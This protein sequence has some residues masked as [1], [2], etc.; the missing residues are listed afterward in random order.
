MSCR[1]AANWMR[2]VAKTAIMMPALV[3]VLAAG[4]PVWA[5]DTTPLNWDEVFAPWT[6][7]ISVEGALAHYG[8]RLPGDGIQAW[9][10]AGRISL[11]PFGNFDLRRHKY[12]KYLGGA[13]ELG[14]EPMFAHFR[15]KGQNFAGLGVAGHYYFTGMSFYRIVPWIGGAAIPGGSDLDLGTETGGTRLTGPFLATIQGEAG[16]S[17]FVTPRQLVYLGLQAEHFS[18]AMLNGTYHNYSLNTPW[19]GVLG[20]TFLFK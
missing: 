16:A 6:K 12:L 4:A 20:Y 8:S 18:N 14:A 3:M 17:Y 13:F 15:N 5:F 9:N 10:L 19:G 2:R 1:V 11:F 7:A